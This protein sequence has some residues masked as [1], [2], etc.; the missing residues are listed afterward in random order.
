M[1]KGLKPFKDVWGIIGGIVIFFTPKQN[2]G[3]I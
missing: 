1:K 3:V 2:Q